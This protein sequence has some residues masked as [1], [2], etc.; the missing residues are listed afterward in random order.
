MHTDFP[1]NLAMMRELPDRREAGH[2]LNV[3]GDITDDMALL[4]VPP[5]TFSLCCQPI[6]LMRTECIE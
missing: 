3:A 2:V 4:K 5:S 1:E 6:S